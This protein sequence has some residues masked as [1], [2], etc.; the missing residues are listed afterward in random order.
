[1]NKIVTLN[2][3]PSNYKHKFLGEG[4]NGACYLTKDGQVYKEYKAEFKYSKN[5]KII[6]N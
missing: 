3:V 4:T 6:I 5:R 1:M 2:E